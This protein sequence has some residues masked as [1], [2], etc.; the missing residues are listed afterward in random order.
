MD[1]PKFTLNQA[2]KS[3]HDRYLRGKVIAI[4]A[5]DTQTPPTV[6]PFD[7]KQE[8]RYLVLLEQPSV[9]TQQWFYEDKIER[10]D[11]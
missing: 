9:W 8:W 4:F 3:V 6:Q 5:H 2:V 10:G 11:P 7:H 1:N